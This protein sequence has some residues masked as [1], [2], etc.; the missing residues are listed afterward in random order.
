[1]WVEKEINDFFL[2]RAVLG[3]R[4]RSE[5]WFAYVIL[6]AP[7]EYLPGE[8]NYSNILPMEALWS[9]LSFSI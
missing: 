4:Q 6:E 3:K 8:T 1:M 9:S 5:V 7:T 2:G